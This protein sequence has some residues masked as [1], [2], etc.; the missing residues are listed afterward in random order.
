MGRVDEVMRLP[1]EVL[2]ATADQPKYFSLTA[3]GSWRPSWWSP[4]ST[5]RTAARHCCWQR[6]RARPPPMPSSSGSRIAASL[7]RLPA[8]ANL[9]RRSDRWRTRRRGAGGRGGVRPRGRSGVGR[10]RG[11]L[12]KAIV[13]AWWKFPEPRIVGRYCALAEGGVGGRRCHR[14]ALCAAGPN[15]RCPTAPVSVAV[16][17]FRQDRHAVGF[18]IGETPTGSRTRSPSAAPHWVL[19]LIIGIVANAV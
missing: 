10:A 5:P 13:T 6:A 3:T 11:H 7:T 19:R 17:L 2:T 12:A 4:T 16:A 8:L 14:R 9:S 1:P 15:D 18:A